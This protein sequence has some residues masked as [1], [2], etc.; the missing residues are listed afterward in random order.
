[1]FQNPDRWTDL[2]KNCIKKKKRVEFSTLD[3]TYIINQL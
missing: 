3:Q 2:Y 1:M